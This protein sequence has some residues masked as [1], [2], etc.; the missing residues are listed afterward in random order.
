M[1][2]PNAC[3]NVWDKIAKIYERPDFVL[4]PILLCG[5]AINCKLTVFSTTVGSSC[6][7]NPKNGV[8]VMAVSKA[9]ECLSGRPKWKGAT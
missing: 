7:G 8:P 5:A 3:R 4:R 9:P 1:V 2:E 6:H